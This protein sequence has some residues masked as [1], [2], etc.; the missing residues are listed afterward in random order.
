MS[1]D[2]LTQKVDGIGNYLAA[3]EV[4]ENFSLVR[5]KSEEDAKGC[6]EMVVEHIKEIHGREYVCSL[7]QASDGS[8]NLNCKLVS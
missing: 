3:V 2:T 1:T 7:E 6:A 4:G 8:Y 5:F